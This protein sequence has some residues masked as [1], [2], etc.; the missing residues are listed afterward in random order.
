MSI[1][2]LT[3]QNYYNAALSVRPETAAY[4]ARARAGVHKF[5]RG[6]A[7]K[8]DAIHQFL[9]D[10]SKFANTCI[11]ICELGYNSETGT[12]LASIGGLGSAP[13]WTMVGGPTLAAG[14]R[15]LDGSTQHIEAADFLPGGETLSLFANYNLISTVANEYI[16]SQYRIEGNR[17]SWGL[18]GSASD[19][20]HI[21]VLLS[22]NGTNFDRRTIEEGISTGVK[23]FAFLMDG[24]TKRKVVGAT[25]S[26][27]ALR[28]G[29]ALNS[30]FDNNEK[31]IV[32]GRPTDSGVAA[33]ANMRARSM[34]ISSTQYTD[35]L[36]IGLQ[37]LLDDL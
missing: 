30:Y 33:R 9:L 13:T 3:A 24:A 22:A 35:A 7:K 36:A 26:A 28:N 18:N 17:R 27:A 10:N 11:L 20:N 2:I 5:G 12:T 25:A 4:C 21:G 32:G 16:L 19:G 14:G 15:L 37:N 23:R 6:E 29:E 8:I 34:G 1:N 31:I